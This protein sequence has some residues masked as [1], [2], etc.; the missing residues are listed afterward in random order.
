MSKNCLIVGGGA[1]GFFTAITAKEKN[2]TLKVTILEKGSSVLQKVKISG[3][4][5][6]NLTHACF[7]PLELVQFYPRGQKELLGPFHQF[8]TGDTMAWFE[9]RGVPLKIENDHRVFPKSDASQSVLDCFQGLVKKLGIQVLTK[10]GVQAIQKTEQGFSVVTEKKTF[11][12][13]QLVI[14]G[15][16]SKHLWRMVAGLGHSIIPPVPS[17]FTFNISD[18]RLSGLSGTTVPNATVLIKGSKFEA[19]GPLLV[20]HWGLSG[21]AVLKLSA[22]AAR[23]LSEQKYRYQVEVNWLSKPFAWVMSEIQ[24][25]KMKNA[26]KQICFRSPFSQM[27]KRLWGSLVQN[28]GMNSNLRWADVNNQQLV[29]LSNLLTKSQ[30]MAKGKSTFKEEFVTAGGVDLKEIN[31]KRFE[32]KLCENL[33]FAGEVLNIDAVTGGFNFQNAWTGGHIVGCVLATN[34]TV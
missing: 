22:F 1:A 19:N 11:T 14:A 32:S 20:T 8:M 33:F 15:G 3:G 9:Q 30:F 6:C 25:T 26:K 4:G 34:R 24:K 12:T 27:S 29:Q 23:F 16:S 17:L 5:R 2:P 13:S 10:H 21:P 31:F 7:D 18:S 28:S